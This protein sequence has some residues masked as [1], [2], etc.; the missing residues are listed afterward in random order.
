[1][2]PN[3]ERTPLLAEPPASRIDKHVPPT[4]EEARIKDSAAPSTAPDGP[5]IPGVK[6]K[7]IL[8]AMAIGVFLAAMD[9]TII[10]SS[11]GAIGSDMKE[12]NK[13]S[14]IATAYLLT[15]TSFQPLYGKLSDIFGRK[16]VLL[17]SYAV[18]GIGCLCC[19]LARSM[20]ELIA[21][22]AFTGV[23]GGGMTTVVSILLSDIVPLRSRGTFQGIINLVFA[24][25]AAI[26]LMKGGIMADS[27]GWRWSFLGQF[28]AAVLA[29][30]VVSVALHL[31]PSALP[32]KANFKDQ[33]KRID[34][35]GAGVLVLAVFA[36]LFGLDR[37]GNLS[38]RDPYAI[39]S[40]CTSLVLFALF[41]LVE[42]KI[43]AEPFAPLHIVQRRTIL[44]ACLA[45][46]FSYSGY[47]AI[48][49]YLPLY[50]QAVSSLA[51][52][53]AGLR[54]VPTIVGG[55][56]GSLFGGIIMQKTGK[57]YYLTVLSYALF[58]FGTIPVFLATGILGNSTPAITTG[59]VCMGFGNG[60]GVT[61]ALIALIAAA[62][63]EEQAVATAM[64]YL[65]RTLGQVT[66][67]SVSSMLVQGSL[68]AE[69]TRALDGADADEIVRKVRSS[70]STIDT[71]T[72]ATRALVLGAYQNALHWAF[73]LGIVLAFFSVLSS[74]F[75]RERALGR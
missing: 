46:F 59:I 57:Y 4:D 14:W 66:G 9:N 13:T 7:L 56:C 47:M 16:P 60:V 54:L 17:F 11:Y 10:V 71:L 53:A 19:G 1:M 32:Q 51:A 62:G 39:I 36:L 49:F 24:T 27:V 26:G 18:F 72:P 43:A 50:Y 38:L 28:P 52:G 69:L 33:L 23:G 37:G 73:L 2:T 22:R 63:H 31:P 35:L 30:L 42:A 34:F 12:L 41:S 58:F 61:S 20:E 65:F 70:L 21:A 6:L 55:V 75:I 67:V 25:G 40:L 74:A 29:I 44:S 5:K 8:P 64:G 68:R 45:Y 15:T 48:L 3:D